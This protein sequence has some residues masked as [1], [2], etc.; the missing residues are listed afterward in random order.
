MVYSVSVLN[1]ALSGIFHICF[2][3]FCFYEE[4]TKLLFIKKVVFEHVYS[5]NFLKQFFLLH[6]FQL[7]LFLKVFA[8]SQ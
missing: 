1:H 8:G 6:K 4:H 5:V 3:Q 2:F 7:A